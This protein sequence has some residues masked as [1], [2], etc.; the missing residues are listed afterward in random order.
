VKRAHLFPIGCGLFGAFLAIGTVLNGGC[1]P[2]DAGSP[3]S[4]VAAQYFGD[5]SPPADNVF[6][7][8]N[9]AEPERLDPSVMSGQPDGRV[10]RAIFEG[11]TAADPRTLEPIPGQAYRWDVSEDGLTYTFHL[12]PGL[13]WNDG[14][15]LV[16]AD[17][18]WT[19]LRVLRPETASRYASFLYPVRNAEEYNKGQLTDS[20][21]VGLSAPDDST[22]VVTL[23][24]PTSYFIYLTAYYTCLPVPRHVIERWGD[25]WTRLEHIVGNGP[26]VM[27]FHRQRDRFEFVKS[28]TYW[29]AA[30]VRLDGVVAYSVDDLNTCVNLYKAG[31]TDW[32]P[33]GYLPSQYVPYMRAF[34]DYRAG[35]YQAVYFYSINTTRPPLDQPLVRRALNLAV[36]REAIARDLLKGSRDPWGNFVPSGYPGYAHPPGLAYDPEAAR[37]CLA[38]A[39]FP[40]GKGMRRIALLFNTSEDHRRIAEAIQEMWK[41]ELGIDVELSNQ[42]WGSYL[43]ATTSL[44]YDV[45]RRSWIGD[46]LDPNTFLSIMVTGDGNNR[47]GWSDATYDRL[48]RGAASEV[49]PVRRLEMLAEAEA[50]LLEWGGVIPIY[51][52]STVELVKPYVRGLYPTALD[53]HPL[54]KIWIDHDWQKHPA[55]A[56]AANRTHGAPAAEA[57]P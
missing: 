57:T 21:Q 34:A 40:G 16:A 6:R 7:Y 33:S 38:R 54:D 36:D 1:T 37:E 31:V 29:N 17:F 8:A 14:R 10:A 24:H 48:V 50:R 15:P 41:R 49:D 23:E 5:V 26:F 45:A 19:W 13:V 32:N 2:R 43:Q 22:F 47:T 39:G 44:Q 52:Y 3:R 46:Y 9:G 56:S 42:E 53:V 12:R 20:T 55:D 11:L 35:R 51:H 18:R 27:T 4:A 30:E 25:R 28:K